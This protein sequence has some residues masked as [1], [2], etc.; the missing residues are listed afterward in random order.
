[1]NLLKPRKWSASDIALIKAGS[2][3]LG[4]AVGMTLPKR[5]RSYAPLLLLG[6]AALSVKPLLSYFRNAE[7]DEEYPWTENESRTPAGENL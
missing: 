3:L 7:I 1:M 2:A 4:V 5:C 6:A